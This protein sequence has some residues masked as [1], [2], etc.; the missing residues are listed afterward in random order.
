MA[1]RSRLIAATVGLLIGLA[2]SGTLAWNEYHLARQLDAVAEARAG[3]AQAGTDMAPAVVHLVGTVTATAPVTDPAFGLTTDA[4]RL[5]RTAETYQWLETRESSGDN[6]LLRYEK[7][8]SPVLIPSDRFEQRSF[9]P[10]PRALRLTTA[11]FRTAGATIGHDAIDPALIDALPAIRELHPEQGGPVHA[12]GLE[13]ARKGDWLFSGDPGTPVVGDVRVRFAEAPEGL[14]SLVAV[15]NGDRLV[16]FQSAAGGSVT[17]VAYGEVPAET[18]L[19]SRTQPVARGLAAARVRGDGGADRHAVRHARADR[20]F[21][22]QPAVRFPATHAH[23]AAAGGGRCRRRLHH[24]LAGRAVADLARHAGRLSREPAGTRS[25]AG[26]ALAL[27][28]VPAH[29][30]HAAPKC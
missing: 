5:D 7:I 4:L 22:R 13:F 21:C 26:A 30:H 28:R 8:W 20:A 23:H 27:A 3:L 6:K 15:R 9:H 1:N 18:L 19:T 10:N 24:Q 12:E 29:L 11:R 2:G 17:L 14:I 16:P 25:P